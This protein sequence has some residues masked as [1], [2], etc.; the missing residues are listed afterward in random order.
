M[1]E[2]ETTKT[3]QRRKRRNGVDR[4]QNFTPWR[5]HSSDEFLVLVVAV[6]RRT[7]ISICTPTSKPQANSYSPKGAI[8][9]TIEASKHPKRVKKTNRAK[10]ING[11]ARERK[12]IPAGNR[13]NQH[14]KARG[15]NSTDRKGKTDDEMNEG[16]QARQEGTNPWFLAAVAAAAA[17]AA[18]ELEVTERG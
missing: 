5:V 18:R 11:P 4:N 12:G 9:S 1:R 8:F 14:Q 10:R 3:N 16:V 15:I 13:K 2:S 6:P 7:Q 17:A